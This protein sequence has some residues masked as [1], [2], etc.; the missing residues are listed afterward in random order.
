MTEIIKQRQNALKMP[1]IGAFTLG[2]LIIQLQLQ[3]LKRL[4][5][6]HFNCYIFSQVQNRIVVKNSRYFNAFQACV[7]DVP[8]SPSTPNNKI[9]PIKNN[10]GN[11]IAYYMFLAWG[12]MAGK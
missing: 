8:I 12:D 2:L 3:H 11:Y 7:F 6:K 10:A 1:V 9:K 4:H 5:L